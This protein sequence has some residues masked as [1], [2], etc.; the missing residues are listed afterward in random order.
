MGDKSQRLYRE[1]NVLYWSMALLD[2][3]YDYIDQC[4]ADAQFPLPFEIPPLRFI[5]AGLLFIYADWPDAPK[6]SGG[7]RPTTIG[8]T[9]LTEEVINGG[10]FKYI[11]NGSTSPRQ[12]TD[13]EAN[14][15]AHF[16]SFTRHVQYTYKDRRAGLYCISDYQGK[17]FCALTHD[18]RS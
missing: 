11:H 10:F 1:A 17:S 9:Y 3:I 6:V 4:I 2:L 14:E 13:G 7:S 8:H 5:E 12:L 18:V 16:L 15:I